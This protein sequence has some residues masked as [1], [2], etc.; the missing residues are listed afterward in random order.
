MMKKMSGRK[1]GKNYVDDD[2]SLVCYA[3]RHPENISD[4]LVHYKLPNPLFFVLVLEGF[5]FGFTA[6]IRKRTQRDHNNRCRPNKR[7]LVNK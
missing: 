6:M 4:G 5:F 2:P 1:S 7:K 3:I